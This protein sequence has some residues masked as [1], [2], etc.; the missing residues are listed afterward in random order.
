MRT[1]NEDD[2]NRFG[3][4][5][6]FSALA[7]QMG[8]LILAAAY[9]GKWLDEKQENNV[10]VWT[11][12]LVLIAIFASLYQIIREVIKISKDDDKK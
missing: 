7:F 8:V 1:P 3:N 12:V 9:G 11:I 5:V 4:Y 10:A 6:K 2:K